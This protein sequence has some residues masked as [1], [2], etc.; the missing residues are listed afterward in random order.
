M[1]ADGSDADPSPTTF[2]AHKRWLVDA[3][4]G[5]GDKLCPHGARG[6]YPLPLTKRELSMLAI[7]NLL[8]DKPEWDSKVFDEAIVAKWKREAFESWE[9]LMSDGAFSWVSIV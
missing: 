3:Y 9:R 1:S 7:M 4:E 2:D 8:T 6:W 5:E